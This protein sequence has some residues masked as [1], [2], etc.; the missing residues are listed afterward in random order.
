MSCWNFFTVKEGS[1]I[2]AVRAYIDGGVSRQ[3][4]R[5]VMHKVGSAY[6]IQKS[7]RIEGAAGKM[8]W[9]TKIEVAKVLSD[10]ATITQAET[11]AAAEAAKADQIVFGCQLD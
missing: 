10:D 9:T 5:K 4:D 8:E 3:V 6:V 7:E 1:K 11:A 2:E